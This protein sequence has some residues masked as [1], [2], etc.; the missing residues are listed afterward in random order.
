MTEEK[1]VESETGKEVEKTVESETGKKK[2]SGRR[3]SSKKYDPK[4]YRGKKL[5]IRFA[6]I[7]FPKASL[8]F[9]YRGVG[10]KMDDQ[11]EISLPIEVIEHLNSLAVPETTYDI[12]EQTGQMKPGPVV[13]RHRF[14]C[15]PVNMSKFMN[16]KGE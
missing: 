12:D 4:K 11:E 1:T 5:F 6:H 7:E 16:K 10:Y 8:Q 15:V 13:L 9:T 3:F 14:S 2:R